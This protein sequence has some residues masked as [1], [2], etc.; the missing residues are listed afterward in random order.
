M[1]ATLRAAARVVFARTGRTLGDSGQPV[2]AAAM[3]W[4][5]LLNGT[6]GRHV[7]GGI[8]VY[9]WAEMAD[10]VVNPPHR[11]TYFEVCWVEDGHGEFVVEGRRHGIGPGTLLFA[12]PGVRH[13]IISASPP[14]IRLS[15]VGF[16]LRPLAATS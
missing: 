16:Q 14:G 15:W 1:V 11:H 13:Q 3:G 8:E 9:H 12:R 2:Y 4:T 5:G 10:T 6:R 7:L